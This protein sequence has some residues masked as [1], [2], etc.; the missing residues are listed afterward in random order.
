MTIPAERYR[1]YLFLL[2]KQGLDARLRA[3]V[4]LSGIVQQTLLEAHQDWEIV[5]DKGTQEQAAWIRR[6][7]IHNLTDEARKWMAAARNVDLERSME[8][9]STN[10]AG[11][12]AAQPSSP[13]MKAIQNED[14]AR[15]ADALL[16][17]P[18]EQRQ[19]VEMHHLRGIPLAEIALEMKRSKSAVAA[20]LY[21]AMQQLRSIVASPP[22]QGGG[23]SL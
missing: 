19:A 13:S 8:Q 1:S 22:F 23:K 12:L 16:T 9:S 4:D 11:M 2:A 7:L 20:L 3:K 14:L 10:L 17:L 6:I 21:R 18:D 15:M 5:A